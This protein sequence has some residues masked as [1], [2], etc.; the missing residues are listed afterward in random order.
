MW[1][2][3]WCILWLPSPYAGTRVCVEFSFF[4]VVALFVYFGLQV[5]YG[6]AYGLVSPNTASNDSCDWAVDGQGY[7]SVYF[8]HI[9]GSKT[10][11]KF[12]DT[13]GFIYT[14]KI[15]AIFAQRR[16]S[17]QLVI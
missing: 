5:C 10:C 12:K 13:R 17:T 2:V 8:S 15:G 14:P 6:N 4:V 16:L 1:H 9:I 11:H 3:C 7:A